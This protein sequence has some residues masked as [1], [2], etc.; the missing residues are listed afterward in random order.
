M[1]KVSPSKVL[2]F[3]L[4]P[5]KF[6]KIHQNAYDCCEHHRVKLLKAL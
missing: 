2:P 5:R 1:I 3:M 6:L 4:L